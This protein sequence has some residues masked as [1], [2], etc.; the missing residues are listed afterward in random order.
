MTEAEWI[1]AQ[2][3]TAP[4]LSPAIARRISAVLFSEVESRPGGTG[5]AINVQVGDPRTTVQ[6]RADL[7]RGA[8]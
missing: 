5:A 7:R 8:S 4:P 3:A 6:P 1:V 2:I